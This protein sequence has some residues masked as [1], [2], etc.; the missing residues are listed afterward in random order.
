MRKG[1]RMG[2]CRFGS[3]VTDFYQTWNITKPWHRPRPEPSP[4]NEDDRGLLDHQIALN[5]GYQR[6]G[7]LVTEVTSDLHG[8]TGALAAATED[9]T[10]IRS[11]PNESSS[12]A[13]RNVSR[14]VADRMAHFTSRLKQ[15]NDEYA[16]IAKDTEDS[17]EFVV[18][19]QLEQSE[20]ADSATDEL[21]DLL[22]SMRSLVSGMVGARDS[23]L[24]F[25]TRLDTL[26]RLERRL[27]REAARASEE[28]LT[29]GANLDKTI[30]VDIESPQEVRLGSLLGKARVIGYSC[31][32]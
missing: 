2:H 18:S 7:S 14:R 27:N 20:A 12:T 15:A 9:F 24:E 32:C 22:S 26:P 29:M 10:N 11:R 19:F 31:A 6:I 5:D 8:L 28:V 17:L 25:A 30:C 4:T 3:P 1:L 21:S 13:A 23:Q 16:T